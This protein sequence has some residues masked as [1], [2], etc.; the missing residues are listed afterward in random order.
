VRSL[1]RSLVV[2][3]TRADQSLRDGGPTG[4]AGH[5]RR[6]ETLEL[7]PR[8]ADRFIGL[9]AT[10]VFDFKTQKGEARTAVE[11]PQNVSASCPGSLARR[12]AA[13]GISTHP[14]NICCMNCPPAPGDQPRPHLTF[15]AAAPQR[16]LPPFHRVNATVWG[17]TFFDARGSHRR[18]DWHPKATD[19]A[20]ILAGPGQGAGA[21]VG[22]TAILPGGT[23]DKPSAEKRLSPGGGLL[24]GDQG[25]SS[26]Q[27]ANDS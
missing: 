14:S 4:W 27:G 26:K 17:D 11:R 5:G 18:R 3:S 16:T 12:S 2:L 10:P 20:G 6:I 23:S 8:R 19:T 1:T 9:G 21:L 13:D 25:R 15:S 7:D 24:A 22:K